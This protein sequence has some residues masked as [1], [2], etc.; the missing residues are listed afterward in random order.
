[1]K[2]PACLTSI[3]LSVGVSNK[4]AP[5]RQ[6]AAQRLGTIQALIAY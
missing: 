6:E 1:M 2:I 4:R 5:Q 3:G